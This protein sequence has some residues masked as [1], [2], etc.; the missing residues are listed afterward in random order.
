MALLPTRERYVAGFVDHL[1]DGAAM[2]VK[3][4]A[5]QLPLYGQQA[6]GTALTALSVAGHL[7][8]VRCAVGQGETT[9]WAFRT[10][11]PRTARDNEWWNAYLAAEMRQLDDSDGLG[12]LPRDPSAGGSATPPP[13]WVPADEPADDSADEPASEPPADQAAPVIGTGPGKGTGLA[14]PAAVHAPGPDQAPMPA[15]APPS[16]PADP[17]PVHVHV[18][19]PNS[20]ARGPATAPLPRVPRACPARPQGHPRRPVR[21]R[22]HRTRTPCHRMARPRRQHRLPHPHPDRR[23]SLLRRF[24][25]RPHPPPAPGQDPAPT[26]HR[27]GRAL[28]R[29]PRPAHPRRVHRLRRPRPPRSPPRRPLPPLPHPPRL[30]GRRGAV[31][32]DPRHPRCSRHQRLR[33]RTPQSPQGALIQQPGTWVP[34]PPEYRSRLHEPTRGI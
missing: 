3:M 23:A 7:R 33:R 4:L 13:P 17:G 6:I 21:R 10:F 26:A 19:T 22:L 25:R 18:Q 1:P 15:V 8:R 14:R 24:T 11:W 27:A 34:K 32:R 5:K 29:G 16:A 2:S 20:P 28:A 30:R 31:R 12:S 9:R